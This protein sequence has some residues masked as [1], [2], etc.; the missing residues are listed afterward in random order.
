MIYSSSVHVQANSGQP[1]VFCSSSVGM[2]AVAVGP[3]QAFGAGA[4]K[5]GR[6]VRDK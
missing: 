6:C 3:H 4:V 5:G 1:G 2:A